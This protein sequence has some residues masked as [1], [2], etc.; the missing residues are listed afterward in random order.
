MIRP[1]MILFALCLSACDVPTFI[2]DAPAVAQSSATPEHFTLPARFALVRTVYGVPRAASAREAELWSQLSNR[3]DEVGVFAPLRYNGRSGSAM[4]EAAREQRFNYVIVVRY[5]PSTGAAQIDL[6]DAAS[7]GLMA[8]ADAV[9]DQG[10]ARGFWSWRISNTAR[11]DRV[12][13]R[14]AE[15]AHPQVEAMLQGVIERAR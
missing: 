8:T 2:G 3:A 13:Y 4:F 10:G 11:L 14:I 15:A 6:F 1:A 5:L 12:T 9:S 7:G